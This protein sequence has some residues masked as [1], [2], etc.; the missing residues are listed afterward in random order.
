MLDSLIVPMLVTTD[1]PPDTDLAEFGTL[2]TGAARAL[3]YDCF[4]AGA[5]FWLD[6][7]APVRQRPAAELRFA[8]LLGR[9]AVAGRGHTARTVVADVRHAVSAAVASSYGGGTATPAVLAIRERDIRERTPETALR[10][11]TLDAA[12]NLTTTA[13]ALL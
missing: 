6:R 2:L 1:L 13:R 7:P 11:S 3:P 5:V 8:A 10:I 4:L 9:L 12:P